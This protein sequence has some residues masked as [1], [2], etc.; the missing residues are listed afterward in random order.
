[1]ARINELPLE[2][3]HQIL[4]QLFSANVINNKAQSSKETAPWLI[5]VQ[6]MGS[7]TQV[8]KLWKHIIT[9]SIFTIDGKAWYRYLDQHENGLCTTWIRVSNRESQRWRDVRKSWQVLSHDHI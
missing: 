2:V 9:T 8:C 5:V 3:L 6:N 7:L 4:Q 1:M